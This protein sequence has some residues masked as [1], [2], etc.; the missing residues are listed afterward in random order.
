MSG[1]RPVGD[2]GRPVRDHDLVLDPFTALVDPTSGFAQRPAG[3]QA[4]G[5]L[6]AQRTA[7]LDVEGLVDRFVTDPHQLIVGELD[8]DPP[9]DLLRT[10]MLGTAELFAHVVVQRLVARQFGSLGSPCPAISLRLRHRGPVPRWRAT[11]GVAPQF[12][13]DR[14]RRPP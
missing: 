10:P 12:P 9:G 4:H 7:P 8:P 13:A 1:D 11:P 3:P 6:P 5:E 2:L 14:C